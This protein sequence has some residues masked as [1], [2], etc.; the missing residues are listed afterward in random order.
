MNTQTSTFEQVLYIAGVP[1]SG[2]SWVGQLL[3]SSPA[4]RFRFQPLFA[5]AFKDW[6]NENSSQQ[7][8]VDL[9]NAMY[10]TEDDYLTQETRRASGEYPI[11]NKSVESTHLVFKE[12][13]YQYLI[14]PILR[15]CNNTK[16]LA[17]VRNPN[18]VLNSWRKNPKEFPPECNILDEWR[19]GACK[20]SGTQDFFGYYK[21]KEAANLFLDLAVKYPERVRVQRYEDLVVNPLLSSQSIFSFAGLNMTE[22]TEGF[23]SKSTRSSNHS[24]CYYAVYKSASVMSQ[25]QSELDPGISREIEADLKDTRLEQFLI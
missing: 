10:A 9:F 8:F 16:L 22:Q 24:D 3:E 15:K 1:R 21:W 23:I 7:Q 14:E 19:H 20:N 5:Y 11:F 4:V 25:W 17:I 2:T 18:A 12:V 13:R 6:V